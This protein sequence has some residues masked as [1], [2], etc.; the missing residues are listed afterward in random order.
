MDY[1]QPFHDDNP[2][3]TSPWGSPGTSPQHNRTTFNAAGA[4]LPPPAFQGFTPNPAGNGLGA[5]EE[6]AGFGDSDTGFGR[7]AT[8]NSAGA[9]PEAQADNSRTDA[10]QSEVEGEGSQAPAAA[11]QDAKGQ[12]EQQ[13]QHQDA[14]QRDLQPRRPAQPLLKL[15]AKV[16]GLE[17]T[18]RKDPILRFDVHVW[19]PS[20]P[21]PFVVVLRLS[22]LPADA[23]L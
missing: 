10:S 18:G 15:Q 21:F 20:A 9:T 5:A 11:Q 8:A 16:T 3:G 22:D 4:G 13:P 7:P 19:R 2:S 23:P 17:R 1:S 14:Q 6:D 12:G